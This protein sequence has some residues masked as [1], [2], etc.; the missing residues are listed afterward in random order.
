MSFKASLAAARRNVEFARHIPPS[1]LLRRAA[2]VAKRYARGTDAI[3]F[4]AHTLGRMHAPPLPLFKPRTHVAPAL[5]GERLTFT[6]LNRAINFRL[7]AV[8]WL[9]P[10]LAP[11]DQLWRMHLHYMEY[12][13]GVGDEL[14]ASL[15]A[16][17]IR[18][19]PPDRPGAWRDS[20]N[21]YALSIR[22]VVWMQ[23]LA[24]RRALPQAVAAAAEA[25]LRRQLCYLERN[26]ETDL[27]GN[28]LIKNIRALLW[29]GAYF[30]GPRA[31]RWRG[32]ALTALRR[33][34][35][36]QILPDGMHFER[37]AS[38]HCQVFADLLECRH[39]L[40][41]DATGGILDDALHR[42]A[43][44]AADLTHPDG[45]VAL[46]ND[47]GL[48]MAYSPADCLDAYQRL[49]GRHPKMRG[50][51]HLPAAGYFGLN[52][53]PVYLVADCGRI[54]PDD[55]PAHGHGDALSF[56]LTV[57]GRR[58]IVDQGVFEYNA[59]ERRRR[60]RTAWNH[61]TLCIA[62]GDQ[63]DFFAAFR[64]G[65]RPDV[66]VLA[67]EEHARGFVLEGTHDGFRRLAGRPTHVRRFEASPAALAIE[68]RVDGAC[69]L[70]ARV[71]FLLHP[72]VRARV[73]GAS[74]LLAAGDYEIDVEASHP[75]SLEPAV[76]WPDLGCEQ[77]T[78]RLVIY[79]ADLG[80]SRM[81]SVR[82]AFRWKTAAAA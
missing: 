55:L 72:S 81:R 48:S 44:V 38:Y 24:R 66:R 64:C 19:N 46:F 29:A 71:S 42:M 40:G 69:P 49:F 39:A 75:L 3:P 41:R 4:D 14:W 45:G 9:A 2:L 56:E 25:S 21:S 1:K 78:L 67:Y 63:A 73:A 13:E 43:Q 70:A 65:R 52:A 10:S 68:D 57:G 35:P 5:S 15:V 37:S 16:Q 12:L 61:N 53:G 20:W 36:R 51:F 50:V 23:E 30:S 6:F 11:A 7:H 22:V 28:H 33:E 62:G 8:D 54:A 26:L 32:T 77:P 59:G 58:V 79:L 27:G 76:W 31:E 60:A 18:A 82:T 34:I 80:A 47:A 74:A 17:W